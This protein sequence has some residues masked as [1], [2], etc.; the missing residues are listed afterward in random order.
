MFNNK[1]LLITGGTGSLGKTV[2]ACVR[3]AMK[4]KVVQEVRTFGMTTSELLV[5]SDWLSSHGCTHVTMESTGIY[6]KPV[7][8]ILE[9]TFVS[10]SAP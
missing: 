5:L 9:G 2:L 1:T 7:W 6:W 8:H 3:V 10:P 4:R